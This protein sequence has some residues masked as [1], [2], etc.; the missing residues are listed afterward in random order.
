MKLIHLF[1]G[2]LC[3]KKIAKD[4]ITKKNQNLL[5]FIDDN[6]K[7]LASQYMERKLFP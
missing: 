2:R 1:T 4:L 3:R 7:K 6:K 5:Y